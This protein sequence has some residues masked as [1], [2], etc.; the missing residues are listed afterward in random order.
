[1]LAL[2]LPL[3]GTK[4]SKDIS[5]YFRRGYTAEDLMELFKK[6]LD[7]IY[8]DTLN[9]IQ[10]FEVRLDRKPRVPEPV[11]GIEDITIGSS[12]NIL[13][14]TGPEGSGKSNYLAGIIAGTLTPAEGPGF[15]TLGTQ[16]S[17]N[18]DGEEVAPKV[19]AQKRKKRLLSLILQGIAL[20]CNPNAKKDPEMDS[21]K[22]KTSFVS[23]TLEPKPKKAAPVAAFFFLSPRGAESAGFEP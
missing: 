17:P 22:T 6:L 12:G 3:P 15:D 18:A 19:Q 14:L 23:P 8:A 9:L 4:E 11:V 7:R 2:A 21:S 10:S 1:M 5:D 20:I 13:A 16:V